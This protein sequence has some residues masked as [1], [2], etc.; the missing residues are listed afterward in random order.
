MKHVG[1]LL[2]VA[3]CTAQQHDPLLDDAAR[4][5][6]DA[7]ELSGQLEIELDSLAHSDAVPK[8]SIRA[9]H[10]AI[11]SWER[12][13]IE[14]PGYDHD[15]QGEAHDHHHHEH[16]EPP[17]DL[18]PE[19]MRDVQRELLQRLREIESRLESTIRKK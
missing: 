1:V 16:R 11:E 6:R 5:H 15:D 17:P 14:V 3:A 8:D 9:W 18:T 12:D 13:V 19:Q 10:L 2:L 7:M 4:Y